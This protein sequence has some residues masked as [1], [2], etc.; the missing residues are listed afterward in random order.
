MST[1]SA[2]LALIRA[3]KAGDVSADFVVEQAT[4]LLDREELVKVLTFLTATMRDLYACKRSAISRLDAQEAMA[5]TELVA[6]FDAEG[7]SSGCG[8]TSA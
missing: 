4:A 3:A 1:V 8:I 2:A 6:Q 5:W 7:G